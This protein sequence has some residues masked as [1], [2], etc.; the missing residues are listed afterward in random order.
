MIHEHSPVLILDE[1]DHGHNPE[2]SAAAT[3]S[4]YPAQNSVSC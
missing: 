2:G 4:S 3:G 1:L